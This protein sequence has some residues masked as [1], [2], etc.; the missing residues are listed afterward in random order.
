MAL[1]HA[2][3]SVDQLV[4]DQLDSDLS[5]AQAVAKQIHQKRSTII[6]ALQEKQ[7]TSLCL[8]SSRGRTTRMFNCSSY[9]RLNCFFQQRR[10]EHGR[11]SI[12]RTRR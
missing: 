2:Q 9:T 5:M 3:G 12:R 1:R 6:Y 11:I 4:L 7:D 10:K 8:S